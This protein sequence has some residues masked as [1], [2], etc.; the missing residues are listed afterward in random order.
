MTRAEAAVCGLSRFYT[1]E[2]CKSGHRT[3]R[4]VSN[5][6]CVACNA[7]AARQ[8]ERLR[9][10]RDPSFRMYRNTLRRTGMALRGRASPAHTLGCDHP[11]LRDHIASQFRTGMSWDGYRQW[12]VDHVRPLSAARKLSELIE[13]CHYSNLQPLWRSE[14]LRKGGA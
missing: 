8:R 10:F 12:E 4:F 2:P 6:Q 13:L 11:V 7:L 3:E 1:G 9:A 5:R 14:N